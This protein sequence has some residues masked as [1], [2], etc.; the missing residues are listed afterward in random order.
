MD[1]K[2]IKL[3]KHLVW[4]NGTRQVLAK[5]DSE[6][7]TETGIKFLLFKF[8]LFNSGQLAAGTC[9]IVTLDRDSSQPRR[10]I[11]RQTARCACRKGQIAG[12][13]RASPACVDGKSQAARIQVLVPLYLSPLEHTRVASD[14]RD[15]AVC[16]Q[17]RLCEALLIGLWLLLWVSSLC[18]SESRPPVQDFNQGVGCLG[19]QDL[20]GTRFR[21][22][23]EELVIVVC[24]LDIKLRG[25]KYNTLFYVF[26]PLFRF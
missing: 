20:V 8:C 15:Y 2:S 23:S 16:S 9:E 21:L 6:C 7:N 25:I 12:T 19:N 11:A 4:H 22:W 26:Q 13:T 10:T 24:L 5:F 18:L 3:L 1:I 14:P 17:K